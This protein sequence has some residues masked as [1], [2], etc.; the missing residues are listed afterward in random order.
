MTPLPELNRRSFLALAG[1]GAGALALSACGGPSTGG[2]TTSG[3]SASAAAED[4]SKV[5]PATEITFWTNHPGKS[6]DIEAKLIADFTAKTGIKVNHVTAG[7]NYEEVAQKFQTAQTGDA[8]NLPHAVIFSDVWWFRYYIN[9]SIIPL[10]GLVKHLDFKVSDYRKSL[11][12]DYTYKNQQWAVPYARSTPL[13]YYN[14][15]HF[16]AAGL[17]DRAPKTW[18]ELEEWAPKLKAANPSA[19]YAFMGAAP[20]DY[21]SW[22]LMNRV[23]GWGGNLSKEFELTIDSPEVIEALT[24]NRDAIKKGWAGVSAKDVSADFAAGAASTI[25]QSTGSLVGIL[26]AATF[27]VGVGF[28]PGGPK[29]TDMVCP[30]GGAGLGIPKAIDKE[31]Q[32]AAAMFLK[33]MGEPDNTA[34]FSN[35]TGYMPVRQSSDMAS[36]IKERPQAQM[37]IDQLSHTKS[38]DYARV[39]IPGADREIGMANAKIIKD[40]A[41]VKETLTTLKATLQKIYDNDVKPKL[42]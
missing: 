21:D 25:Q 5:T 3:A 20:E 30:T 16:K 41:D 22:Y 31:H 33:F 27:K 29:A 18:M 7:A 34:Q 9:N 8:K 6:K 42:K 28:M 17:P 1:A 38:Q 13:F 4:W 40:G 26:K 14:A 24:W 39:F 2:N 36:I 11:W 12:G 15:D 19:T 32:L 23:W 35:A 10:D 37:A